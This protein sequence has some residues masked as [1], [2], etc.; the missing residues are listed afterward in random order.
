MTATVT[1]I[2]ASDPLVR[3]WTWWFASEDEAHMFHLNEKDELN[4]NAFFDY[5]DYDI[6]NTDQ[7]WRLRVDYLDHRRPEVSA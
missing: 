4:E 6:E 2:K 1:S 3:S 7:G 5:V